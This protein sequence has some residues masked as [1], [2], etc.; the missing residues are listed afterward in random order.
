MQ[1][2]NPGMDLLCLPC[3]AQRAGT[4]YKD[5]NAL[6]KDICKNPR[7]TWQRDL[8]CGLSDEE[9][10]KIPANTGECIKEAGGKLINRFY[11]APSKLHGM[12]SLAGDLCW[13][14]QAGTGTFLHAM[15][16]GVNLFTHFGKTHGEVVWYYAALI[17]KIVPDGGQ[18][19]A[20]TCV[21]T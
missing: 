12:D 18:S 1:D 3:T 9:R 5:F 17:A 13:K 7:I 11:F 10:L 2:K 4:F 8:N 6:E 19:T 14:R 15:N 16:G 20:S 21:K